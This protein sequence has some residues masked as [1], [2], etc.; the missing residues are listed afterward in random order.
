MKEKH[1]HIRAEEQWITGLKEY[2]AQTNVNVSDVVRTAV[3]EYLQR[4]TDAG[5]SG[6]SGDDTGGGSGA[7]NN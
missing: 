5:S 7:T 4:G 3:N 6:M 1:L 2:A